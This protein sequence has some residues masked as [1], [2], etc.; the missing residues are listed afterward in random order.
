MPPERHRRRSIPVTTIMSLLAIVV[1][2]P[3][4]ANGQDDARSNGIGFRV[5]DDSLASTKGDPI[6]IEDGRVLLFDH[7]GGVPKV[8]P[9]SRVIGVA[10][11]TVADR[12]VTPA[13]RSAIRRAGDDVAFTE[14]FLEFIDG[15]RLKG[16]IHP[17]EDG[18]VLWR[19][20]WIRDLPFDL[21]R[22]R[23]IRFEEGARVG[24][25]ID[26]DVVILSNGDEL[27]GLV[28]DIGREVVV[29]VDDAAGGA[30]RRVEVPIHRVA[31]VALVNPPMPVEGAMTL[32]RGGHR[33][34]SRGV[35]IGDD[36]YLR[37]TEPL[38][39]GD[40]A[41]V[42]LEF[43]VSSAFQSSRIV[44]L[45]TLP[46]EIG[47]GR[48]AGLRPWIPPIDIEAGH[49][50]FDA[51]PIELSGPMRADFELPPGPNRVKATIERP[52]EAGPG[53][54][55]IVVLDDDIEVARHELDADRPIAEIVV[56]VSSGRLRFEVEDGGDGPYRDAVIVREAIVIRPGG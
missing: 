38:L 19:S 10:V 33:I 15:Q 7:P 30:P 12:D 40:V 6:T 54:V 14:P 32:L 16:D 52:S 26:S 1:A 53:R 11:G 22:I 41:E 31:S 13:H 42:P 20:A 46:V 24:D 23:A 37:L 3:V 43:L 9:L 5:I 51:A 21:E 17:G 29:E 45:A 35:R 50:P 36:G 8:V 48:N 4:L 34:A 2:C 39:G 55:V 47:P 56:P 28:D 27:R 49:H 44:P 18:E 25:A